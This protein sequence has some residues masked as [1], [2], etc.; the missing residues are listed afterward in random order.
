MKYYIEYRIWCFLPFRLQLQLFATGFYPKWLTSEVHAKRQQSLV[1]K[2]LQFQR[3][4]GQDR[5]RRVRSCG[6]WETNLGGP[7]EGRQKLTAAPPT[8]NLLRY[9]ALREH[10]ILIL[11]TTNSPDQRS[12]TALWGRLVLLWTSNNWTMKTLP[13]CS[14]Q[15]QLR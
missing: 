4:E 13:P 10:L 5:K 2:T 11:G 8:W 14:L 6:G 3:T 12:Q 7:L 9:A 15:Y 1:K